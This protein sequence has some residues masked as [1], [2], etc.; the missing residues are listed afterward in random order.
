MDEYTSK[1]AVNNGLYVPK[2]GLRDIADSRDE[3]V[4]LCSRYGCSS[5]SRLNSMKSP[6]VRSTTEKPRPLRPSFTSSNGKE[7]VGS[8]CRTSSSPMPN[9]RKS[10]KDRKS[11]SH[12]GN[13][14]SENTCLHGEP[15]T[16]GYMK[17]S[18][19][20]RDAGSSKITLT[21]VGC[22]SGASSSKPRRLFS[23]KY[24]T[25][26]SPVGPTRGT[27]SRTGYVP[28]N[29]KCNSSGSDVSPQSCST[30]DSRFSRRD[31]VK[32]RNSEGE[33]TSSSSKGKKVSGALPTR[34]ISISDSRSSKNFD[35]REDSRAVSVRTRRSMNVPRFR[36]SI[37]D[38]SSGYFQNSSQPESPNLSLQ[39]SSQFFSYACSSDSSAYS[40]PGN[41][42][43]DLPS[44]EVSGTSTELGI[45]RLMNRD[46]LQRYNM[47]GVAQVLVA[48]ER[49]EQDE[50][51]TYEQLLVLETNLFLG[52]LNFYDQHR[53]MRLDIDNMSYEE[54]LALEERMGSVSTALSEEALSKCLQKSI[55]QAMPS[56]IGEFGSN[57]SEDEVKCTICQ[58][59][60]VIGDEI[61][62]LE[63]E[64]GSSKAHDQHLN[65]KTHLARASIAPGHHDEN[66]VIIKPLPSQ[67]QN[68]PSDKADEDI[69]G[70]DES[71][72]EEVDPEEDSVDEATDSLK[73]LKMNEDSYLDEHIEELDPCCCFMCDLEH[74]TIESFMV[75]MHKKHGFFIPDVEYLKDPKGF[76]T[77]LGLMV[78]RDYM[79]LY[80]NDRCHS[81]SSLE[82]VRKHMDAKSHCKV[83]YGDGGD[84]EE[85]EL[86]KFYDCSGRYV[87]AIGKQL[88][89]SEDFN[90]RV[91]LV[92]TTRADDGVS[93]KAL[94]SIEFLRYYRQK[95]RPT[96]TND[97]AISAALASRY[98]SM[99][100]ATVQSR[101]QMVKMKVLKAMNRCDVDAMRSKIG[102]KA[103]AFVTSLKMYNISPFHIMCYLEVFL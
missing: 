89:S 76:L 55:Y 72:W 48:L 36:D 58:E 1:R 43:E 100:L 77:Y 31:I 75:H 20:H 4:Q 12:V 95:P 103:M 64:H 87:D 68:E 47:D 97:V 28:R 17:S 22:S 82:A 30:T 53:G 49:M 26:N 57:E 56:E 5:S 8:S 96:R 93:V 92:I 19:A 63:C 102:M 21:E 39:S 6:Q 71:E 10:L 14:Q 94:G 7:V 9:A 66:S 70:G 2:R 32:R 40:F 27:A 80:C 38:A 41:D 88:V 90:D 35:I 33:S 50:E 79:C 3:N 16:S 44:A 45:N 24:S 61:G 99:G 85:A 59:E 74:K 11:F 25:Q 65:S 13:N 86:E 78:K 81:F 29:L 69:S 54:L 51:L 101:E 42:V 60:Y 67:P 23:P 46:A 91:E 98:R 84:D 52:G 15:E 18:K 37:R 83:H 34:G 73:Q 62:R